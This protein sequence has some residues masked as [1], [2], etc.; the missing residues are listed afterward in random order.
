MSENIENG[1]SVDVEPKKNKKGDS[2]RLPYVKISSNRTYFVYPDLSYYDRTLNATDANPNKL[3][4]SPNWV[5][6]EIKI[7]TGIHWYPS[8]IVDWGT[9]KSLS[10]DAKITIGEMSAKGDADADKAASDLHKAVNDI[11]RQ[12]KQFKSLSNLGR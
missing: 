3:R 8:E 1:S 6:K 11:E 9:V 12:T 10:A 5:R 4:V 7:R 2:L